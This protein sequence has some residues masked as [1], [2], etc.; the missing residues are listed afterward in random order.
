MDGSKFG[1][2]FY[3]NDLSFRKIVKQKTKNQ[4]FTDGEITD[5]L[6][7]KQNNV[8]INSKP[9][10]VFLY[11]YEDRGWSTA[12]AHLVYK[13]N[14]VFKFFIRNFTDCRI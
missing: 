12:F 3:K 8:W 13:T 10:G 2:K 1:S 6:V 9:V 11:K 14:Q 5:F 7:D 4:V